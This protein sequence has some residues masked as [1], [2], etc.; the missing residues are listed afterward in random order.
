MRTIRYG[1]S[2]L[3]VL[4]A[5]LLCSTG[6][7]AQSAPRTIGFLTDFD[8]KDDAVG[9]CRAV[10]HGIAPTATIIDI[11]HQVTPFDI[12]EGS[13]FLAGSASYFPKD[14][15][16]VAVIDPGVGS[17]RKA[18]IV[19][20]KTGQY[21]VL[22]DNGLITGIAERDEIE[23]AREITNVDWMIGDRLSST[24]HGR[25]IF[26][27]AG[28]HL[29]RG[30][31]WVAAGPEIPVSQLIRLR[32]SSA[33]LDERGLQAEVIGT[34][35]PFGNLVLNVPQSLFSKLGYSYKDI[36]RLRLGGKEYFIPFVRTFDDVPVGKDLLYIDS[37]DRLSIAVNQGNFA[38]RSHIDRHTVL[39][40]PY[41]DSPAK[42]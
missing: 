27:P 13:R 3:V 8:T 26:S 39:E 33:T 14:A 31:D 17:S 36:V 28:A 2:L 37:R 34:D 32:G 19:K 20:S 18:V 5:L 4:Q 12:A 6:I 40:I 16:F 35:G 41:K 1:F 42:R 29:A 23:A 30:D 24:F 22:P 9:I 7:F 38:E 15:I 21:F 10:M 25:D 11:T